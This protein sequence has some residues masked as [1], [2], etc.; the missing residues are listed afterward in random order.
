M[1]IVINLNIVD[2]HDQ[3]SDD[4]DM[5][6][7]FITT[8]LCNCIIKY[9]FQKLKIYL[10]NIPHQTILSSSWYRSFSADMS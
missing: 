6:V 4:I 5:Y 1:Y 9:S 10:L 8:S 7:K 2:L 3:Y